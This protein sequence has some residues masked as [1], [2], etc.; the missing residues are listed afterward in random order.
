MSLSQFKETEHGETE[1][2]VYVEV[3]N[4][5]LNLLE[6]VNLSN[7][8]PKYKSDDHYYGLVQFN[9]KPSKIQETYCPKISTDMNCVSASIR[10]LTRLSGITILNNYHSQKHI[11]N[12]GGVIKYIKN[13][14]IETE[15][16]TNNDYVNKDLVVLEINSEY[17]STPKQIEKIYNKLYQMIKSNSAIFFAYTYTTKYGSSGHATVVAKIKSPNGKQ[18]LY[19]IDPSSQKGTNYKFEIEK[20]TL[21]YFKEIIKTFSN[22]S[23]IGFNHE[24]IKDNTGE[25]FNENGVFDIDKRINY[26]KSND[27]VFDDEISPNTSIK[28]ENWDKF[29]TEKLGKERSMFSYP[30]YLKNINKNKKMIIS[31]AQKNLITDIVFYNVYLRNI[32]NEIKTSYKKYFLSNHDLLAIFETIFVCVFDKNEF[33]D[34][35]DSIIYT[36]YKK[37]KNNNEI[38]ISRI[39]KLRNKLKQNSGKIFKYVN[40]EWMDLEKNYRYTKTNENK[41]LQL[42]E[43]SINYLFINL[44]SL[45]SDIVMDILITLHK[46]TQTQ[47]DNKTWNDYLN[48]T[49]KMI[50]KD[51]VT[52]DNAKFKGM[53]RKN[54]NNQ[55]VR[56]KSKNNGK[57]KK[58]TKKK[59]VKKKRN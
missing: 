51:M 55:T 3:L 43:L 57:S 26:Q 22:I 15:N 48:E 20:L 30:L 35:I 1:G 54:K 36:N 38:P 24:W 11:N 23:I 41:I 16:I 33:N 2:E 59:S 7:L 17:Y 53:N 25:F 45:D 28:M 40:D 49:I 46:S 14:F 9:H 44:D 29:N 52:K 56:K 13:N 37:S 34:K 10:F 19:H 58:K 5:D 12:G 6:R 50:K 4:E 39:T 31:R 42:F 21:N 47:K 18:E 32:S 27:D 8:R